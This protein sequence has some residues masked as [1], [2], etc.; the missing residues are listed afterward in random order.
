MESEGSG[1]FRQGIFADPFPFFPPFGETHL[2]YRKKLDPNA[3]TF[4]LL[5][6]KPT[7]HC[8]RS[9]TA[10]TVS[11]P[12]SINL[13]SCV[14]YFLCFDSDSDS[15]Y[16]FDLYLDLDPCLRLTTRSKRA[17]L[18]LIDFPLNSQT[19]ILCSSRWSVAISTINLPSSQTFRQVFG[20]MIALRQPRSLV[21]ACIDSSRRSFIR[22]FEHEGK[23]V[24]GQ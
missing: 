20:F 5:Q 8:H 14:Q 19:S 2:K 9:T 10:L 4:W 15:D 12:I 13:L 3:V 16:R 22:L 21:G 18:A 23:I 17:T 11:P 7:G 24:R 6:R 1:L